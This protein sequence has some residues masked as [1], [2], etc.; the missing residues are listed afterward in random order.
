[1]VE[2]TTELGKRKAA[3]MRD[4]TAR[5]LSTLHTLLYRVT[6]GRIGHRLVN[7]DMLLLTTTGRQSG[8]RHTVPLLYLRDDD[9]LVVI[10][11]WGGRDHH[12]EWFLNLLADERAEVQIDERRTAVV[13]VTADPARR[14]ALW[15]RVLAAYDGY[16]VYESRTDREIPVVILRPVRI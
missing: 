8:K 13:A 16:R 10:A 3:A 7:N 12:P 1:M 14:E 5:H 11:S 9:D 4:N 2:E 15:P 6:R